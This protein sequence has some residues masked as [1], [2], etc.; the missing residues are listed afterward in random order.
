MTEK[1]LRAFVDRVE[2]G[3]AVI[4]LEEDGRQIDWPI[5]KLPPEA[6]EGALL[7]ITVCVEDKK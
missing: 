4:L 6:I 2:N 1:T 7:T 3:Y 5:E